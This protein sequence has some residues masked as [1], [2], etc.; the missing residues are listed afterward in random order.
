MITFDIGDYELEKVRTICVFCEKN[1]GEIVYDRTEK[2]VNYLSVFPSEIFEKNRWYYC[3]YLVA[4]RNIFHFRDM[5][6][7]T[8]FKL[9]FA[10]YIISTEIK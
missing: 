8:L 6:D 1:F 3:C 10:H 9:H 7:A 2:G 5:S 4:N